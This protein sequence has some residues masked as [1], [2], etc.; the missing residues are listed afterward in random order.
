MSFSFNYHGATPPRLYV[1]IVAPSELK[2]VERE[3]P[4]VETLVSGK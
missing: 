3:E 1:P 4:S 2:T